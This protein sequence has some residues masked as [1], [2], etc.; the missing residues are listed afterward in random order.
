MKYAVKAAGEKKFDIASSVRYTCEGIRSLIERIGPRA[1]G[2]P[3][4]FAAQQIMAG[5][6]EQ[7][8]DDVKIE[9]FKVHRQAFMGFIP[10]TVVMG[11]LSILMFWLDKNL[12]GFI[13][14]L[15]GA[16]PAIPEFLMYKQFLDPLF[17]EQT[18]H[19][20]YAVRKAKGETKKRIILCGHSDSQYEWTLNYLLG[21][22]GM[23]AVLIPAVVGMIVSGVANLIK[24]IL[25]QNGVAIEGGLKIFFTVVGVVLILFVPLILGFLLFQNPFRSVPGANDNLTG[26]YVGMSV[27]KELANADIRFENTEVCVMLSG[28]EEAGLRGA[29]AFAKAHKDELTEIETVVIALD[30]FRDT[31]TLAIYDRDLSGTLRH[32]SQVKEMVKKAGANCGLNLTYE[33]IYI[34]GSDAAAFTQQGIKSTCFNA[35]DPTPPRYYHTRLD[36]WEI[37]VPEAIQTGIEV[38]L[39]TV[40]MY[41]EE[42]L[43]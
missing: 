22:I 31:E 28:S 32:D 13:L 37:M 21:G 18:S 39:E 6:L 11:V 33:S 12:A 2:S 40:C 1:P 4:E 15:L 43:Q 27:L 20:V 23:K 8:A 26:C 5:D 25:V 7:W 30:T 35:M 9:E 41:D 24:F 36:S 3:Q 29:K 42:G 38:M 14:V 10:F 19:N 16:F 34:G 17:P